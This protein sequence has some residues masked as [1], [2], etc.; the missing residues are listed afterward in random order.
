MAFVYIIECDEKYKVGKA[1]NVNKRLK[2]LKTANPDEIIIIRAYNCYKKAYKIETSIKQY[3][4]NNNIQGE[5][6]NISKADFIY[7]DAL[8]EEKLSDISF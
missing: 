3:L 2:Q 8:V 1:N 7:I 5:W 4:K 6:Y